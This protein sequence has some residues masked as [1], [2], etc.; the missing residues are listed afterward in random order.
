MKGLGWWTTTPGGATITNLLTI[1]VSCL[2][3]CIHLNEGALN[4]GSAGSMEGG[5]A[6]QNF[7]YKIS[8]LLGKVA[9][10]MGLTSNLLH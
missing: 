10:G 7:N 9:E 1:S 4:S 2:L 5:V 6:P 8:S 3:R